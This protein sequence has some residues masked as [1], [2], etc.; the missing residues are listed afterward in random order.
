[1]SNIKTSS[2]RAPD[3]KEIPYEEVK[4]MAALQSNWDKSEESD[5]L[6]VEL[7]SEPISKS[8]DVDLQNLLLKADPGLS[9][10]FEGLQMFQSACHIKEVLGPADC[11]PLE[12]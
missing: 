2:L 9:V 10:L 3:W 4:K 12:G 11:S 8:N 6:R 7:E 1:M 5:K